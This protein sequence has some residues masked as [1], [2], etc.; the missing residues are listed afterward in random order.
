VTGSTLPGQES[1]GAVSGSLELAV[2]F[3]IQMSAFFFFFDNVPL[4]FPSR[5]GHLT[6]I[7]AGWGGLGS[8]KELTEPA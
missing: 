1:Q 7:L 6:L 8:V 5:R 3:I 4:L 2:L